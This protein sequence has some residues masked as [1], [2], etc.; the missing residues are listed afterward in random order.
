M[1]ITDEKLLPKNNNFNVMRLTAALAV[2]ISHASV[3]RYGYNEIL[4]QLTGGRYLL[5]YI[6]L[7]AF[8]TI[9]G[10]L[11]CRS[12]VT[13]KT[14]K[15]YL[16]KRFVRIWPA[17]AM[18]TLLTIL[19]LGSLFSSLPFISF[20][21]H[22]QT[23][24]FFLKNIS[25]LTVTFYLP[26]VFNGASVN[27]SIWTIPIEVRLYLLLL[28]FFL[29]TKLHFRQWLLAMLVMICLVRLSVPASIQNSVLSEPLQGAI[30]F[31]VYFLAGACFYLYRDKLP[32]TWPIWLGLLITWLA[33]HIWLPGYVHYVEFPFLGYSFIW[34][35]LG[36]PRIPFIKADFSYGL[37]LYASP[38]QNIIEYSIG[39]QLSFAG[40][41]LSII[42]ASLLMGM[43]SWW[44]IEQPVLQYKKAKHLQRHPAQ[45]PEHQANKYE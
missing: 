37:Y 27:A 10:F 40:Y 5:T 14:I 20:I 16:L 31:G 45:Q 4:L 23:I 7:P 44:L 22:P 11:V 34:M 8:F 18:C 9:S 39:Q 29:V 17:Y 12:L 25:T 6:A 1:Y 30:H 2:L 35:A 32:L 36:W 13:T 21:G 43:L 41:M 3:G 42:T 33:L 26:G 24:I 19:V 28:L 38:V 15:Q